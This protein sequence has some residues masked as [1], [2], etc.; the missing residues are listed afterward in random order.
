MIKLNIIQRLLSK[1]PTL[2]LRDLPIWIAIIIGELAHLITPFIHNPID[3]IWSDP[4]RWWEYASSGI[5]T[6]PLALIDAP[7]YQAWLSFIAKITLDIPELTALYSALLSAITPWLWYKFLREILDSKRLALLGWALISLNPSWI[8]I[9]SYFMTETLLLPLM[10]LGLWLSFRSMRKKELNSFLLAVLI[11]TIAGMTRGVVAPI[12]TVIT[13]F[14]W[15]QQDNKIVSAVLASFFVSIVL[16]LSGFRTYTKIGLF[17]PIGIPT[18]NQV[19]A[20]SGAQEINIHLESKKKGTYF[21]YGFGS[22]SINEQPFSP[23]S[24]WSSNRTGKVVMNID[25]D[26]GYTSWRQ[27]KERLLKE[28]SPD[29]MQ[30]QA[31]NIILLFFG[32]SW[33][34]NNPNYF[35]DKLSNLTLFIWAPLFIIVISL[36]TKSI[37]QGHKRYNLPILIALLLW[38][39]V[40]G[41]TLISVNE[42]RYRKPIEAL[43]IAGLLLSTQKR[44]KPDPRCLKMKGNTLR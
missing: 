14:V 17:S 13:L 42:G 39:I 31:E 20:R 28:S 36:L 8:G 21:I 33:P 37:R 2:N 23:I 1:L 43:L 19:Y 11:W 5:D 34:D 7:F 6:P 4:G 29:L 24:N 22:P 15:L 30:L 26:L 25:L 38:F 35:F 41:L 40:Q 18:M 44:G 32:S 10:G 12:A 27:E 3:H 9:Y 16:G